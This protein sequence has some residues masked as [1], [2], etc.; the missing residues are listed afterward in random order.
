M[1]WKS[2]NDFQF[3]NVPLN[4]I[5]VINK[6]RATGSECLRILRASTS[7]SSPLFSPER[8]HP[9]RP[10]PKD[11]LKCNVD[12][13]YCDKKRVASLVAIIRDD[14]GKLVAGKANKI[15]CSS[16]VL[17]EAQTIHE[18]MLLASSCCYAS[19]LIESDCL[20]VVEAC[21][22]KTPSHE[23][24]I[25]VADLIAMKDWFS[26]CAL[27]WCPREANQLAHQLAHLLLV[28]NLIL[29]W[30]TR[31]PPSVQAILQ[32]HSHSV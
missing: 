8:R 4:P 9:W 23:I 20:Q 31:V 14:H 6:P 29:D 5:L 30:V 22:N 27:L 25:V 16:S 12:A 28:G 10:P 11:K 2:R 18:G 17:A 1:I 7:T 3:Q 26:N 15:P 32:K 13:A 24:A 19:V 21:W